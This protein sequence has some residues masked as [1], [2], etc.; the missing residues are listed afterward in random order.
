VTG[1]PEALLFSPF[2][3]KRRFSALAG[4][5][6]WS[7]LCVFSVIMPVKCV[8]GISSRFHYRRLAFCFLPQVAILES[9]SLVLKDN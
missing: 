2:N 6:E 4:G 8:S 5:V 3:V 9:P 7:K 1:S